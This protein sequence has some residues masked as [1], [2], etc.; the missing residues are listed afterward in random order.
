M[1][2]K[3]YLHKSAT[4]IDQEINLF[5][6]DLIKEHNHISN[7]LTPL[8]SAFS[9]SCEGGKRIRGSL[10]KLGFEIAG[11]RINKQSEIL[12]IAVAYEIFQ[13]AILAH[14]DIIDKSVLRRGKA[15]LYALLGGDHEGLSK[16]M[17]LG[18]IGFFLSFKVI[19]ESKFSIEK[20]NKTLAIFSQTMLDTGVGELLDVVLGQKKTDAVVLD[21]IIKVY[22]LKTANYTFIAPLMLG[23]ILGGLKE[24]SLPFVRIFGK[25]LGIA[26]QI[27]DDLNDM[28]LNRD[29]TGK[30]PGGDIKEGKLTL[31]YAYA[32]DKS[33]PEERLILEKYYGNSNISAKEINKVKDV[34]I[35]TGAF[36]YASTQ[37]K[38]YIEESK[39]CISKISPIK[40]Y[41]QLLISMVEHFNK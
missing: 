10:V 36:E 7:R 5:F 27:Q 21:E 13:A 31:L 41:E 11:G 18:D 3:D 1:Y 32:L 28:L 29:I 34:M 23:A 40:T 9:K 35:S 16:A 30:E 12:K 25:N 39:A 37:K 33:N 20:K 24:D 14:D 8:V 17:C 38:Y 26:F 22:E 2:F 19:A 6:Q 4:Q 15:S